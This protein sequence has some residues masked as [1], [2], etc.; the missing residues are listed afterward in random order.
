MIIAYGT[1]CTMEYLHYHRI[2]HRNLN[3]QKFILDSHLNPFIIGFEIKD[4]D[5]FITTPGYIAPEFI[6]GVETCRCSNKLDI[7]SFGILLFKLIT[8]KDPNQSFGFAAIANDVLN[9]KS[10]EF[11]DST[12]PNWKDLIEK[13]R[14]HDHSRMSIA[15]KSALPTPTMMMLSG[16]SDA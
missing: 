13:C 12:L 10:P 15:E 2:V 1:A 9:G 5:S 6:D 16:L 7:Y 14:S 11:P 3:P 4:D 8:E